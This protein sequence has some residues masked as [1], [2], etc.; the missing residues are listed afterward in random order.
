MRIAICG[1]GGT[2]KTTLAGTLARLL[3]QQ[4]LRVLAIDGDPN[5]N[6]ATA[7]GLDPTVRASLRP[8]PRDLISEVQ[9]GGDRRRV[10]RRPAGEI[11]QT[12]GR[13]VDGGLTLLVGAQVEHAGAG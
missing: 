11:V 8:L 13:P 5:P 3:A 1:K 7:L 9:E 4:G 2:G 12:Y 10:L 6:L